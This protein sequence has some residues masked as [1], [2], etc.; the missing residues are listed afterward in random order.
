MSTSPYAGGPVNLD[1]FL[2]AIESPKIRE[3]S[4][5]I[6]TLMAT[7]TGKPA[8]L[9]GGATLGFD[10]Y[11]YH[12]DSGRKGQCHTLG[13]RPAKNKISIYL[14]DGTSK[15]S[16][17]LQQLGPHK[18]SKACLYIT[19]LDGLNQ[20][21]LADILAKSYAYVSGLDGQMHRV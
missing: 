14:M 17:E 2:D 19:K 15:Y 18:I 9:W 5:V 3:A 7:I 12:Y 11:R 4:R 1:H 20:D 8:E 6:A 16:A 21:V 10:C 13:F